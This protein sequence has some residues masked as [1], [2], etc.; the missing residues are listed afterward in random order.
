MIR[1]FRDTM[2]AGNCNPRSYCKL[3]EAVSDDGGARL[4]P[5]QSVHRH[6]GSGPTHIGT[7]RDARKKSRSDIKSGSGNA[8]S[9]RTFADAVPAHEEVNNVDRGEAGLGSVMTNIL[10]RSLPSIEYRNPPPTT[11]TLP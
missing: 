5:A 3:A 8:P 10:A 1:P 7:W 11:A 9:F 4:A 2:T 6:A